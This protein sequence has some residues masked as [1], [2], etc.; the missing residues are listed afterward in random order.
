MIQRGN[1]WAI[2]AAKWLKRSKMQEAG[3]CFYICTKRCI[4][5]YF[6]NIYN[7]HIMKIR[8]KYSQK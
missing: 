1:C 3:I 5:M 4:D 6:V 7:N 8:Y 2:P